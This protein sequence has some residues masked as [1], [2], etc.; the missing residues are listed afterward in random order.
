MYSKLEKNHGS[1]I[2]RSLNSRESNF[3]YAK[4][5]KNELL[6][7]TV[8]KQHRNLLNLESACSNTQ[9]RKEK[10]RNKYTHTHIRGEG[11]GKVVPVLN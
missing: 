11:K 1:C 3:R 8:T 4:R 6:T 7:F 10:I 2:V 9:Q 5:W